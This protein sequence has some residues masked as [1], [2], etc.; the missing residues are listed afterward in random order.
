MDFAALSGIQAFTFDVFGTVVDWHGT[1]S[2]EL[3]DLQVS[4]ALNG[5]T[6][7]GRFLIDERVEQSSLMG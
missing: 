7:Q 5:F 2:R 1:V 4:K 6:S 3:H